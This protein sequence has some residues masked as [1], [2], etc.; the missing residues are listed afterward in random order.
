MST[1]TVCDVALRI[2]ENT[3]VDLQMP[4]NV[5]V[6]KVLVD[7]QHYLE[8][9]LA[10]AG[11]PDPL[12]DTATAWRL[13]TPIGTLLDNGLS[14]EE[15][16]IVNGAPL[17]LIAA[18]RGEEF[19][20]RIENVSVFV[21]RISEQLFAVAGR[22]AVTA[23]LIVYCALMLAGAT[24]LLQV[25]AFTAPTVWHKAAAVAPIAGITV[26]AAAN[27]RWKRAR[28][29]TDLCAAALL[30]LAPVSLS[31]LVPPP[32]NGA[33]PRMLVGAATALGVA[34]VGLS[35][36]RYVTAYTA[37]AVVAG[38]V[39]VAELSAIT[40]AVPGPRVQ[41]LL[42]WLLVILL[43]RVELVAERLARL[44]IPTFPSG[45]GQ[46][47]GRPSGPVGTDNLV[48]DTAPPDPTLLMERSVRANNYQTGLLIGL[49]AAALA[50]STL[51]AATHAND[52]PW[53]ALAAGIPVIFAYR[54]WDFAGLTNVVSLL[55]GVFGP[56]LA[57][58]IVLAVD[59]GV[60]WGAAA[61]AGVA[62]LALLAP[63]SIPS[64]SNPQAPLTRAMRVVS[65]NLVI[66]AVLLAPVILLRIP[67]MVY[68]RSFQ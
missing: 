3:Q 11:S 1:S 58:A 34:V 10:D 49:S 48:P 36:R 29:I 61:A 59:H 43:T 51:I 28:L 41:G 12:P 60:W 47:L 62:A 25:Q 46:F 42:V 8:R 57:L 39:V 56:A 50:L 33:G 68:N 52:W 23:A 54:T 15:Q 37:V 64:R 17:E 13:R 67:Q 30:V 26:I 4:A 38:F 16:H 35:G 9:Y 66:L 20:P 2:G 55:G 7:V 6:G 14:L 44:P 21:A 5:P 18:P 65:G 22:R 40:T 31:V 19:K 63:A 53:L 32:W 45:S 24:A 27:A